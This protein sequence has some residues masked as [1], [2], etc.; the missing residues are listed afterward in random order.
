MYPKVAQKVAQ[1]F[2]DKTEVFQ[3]FPKSYRSFRLLLLEILYPR[4]L[5]NCPIWSHWFRVCK[6]VA[7][8]VVGKLATLEQEMR[9]EKIE[10]FKK[11]EWGEKLN[12]IC[13]GG[14]KKRR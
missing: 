12:T 6:E 9:G 3:N 10:S 11:Q 5:K 7:V 13:N 14:T 2:L 4:T 8:V 1:V